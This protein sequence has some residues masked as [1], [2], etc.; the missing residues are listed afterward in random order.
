MRLHL[1]A[2]LSAA[3]AV[4]VFGLSGCSHSQSTGKSSVV[5]SGP[6]ATSTT[7]APVAAPQAAPLPAPEALTDVLYRLADPAVPGSQKL[8]LV[9]DSAPDNAAT[10][11]KFTAALRDNGYLPLSFVATNIAWSDRDPAT[12]VAVVNVKTPNPTAGAFSFPMEFKPYPGGWQLSRKT[13]DTLLAF[14]TSQIRTSQVGTSQVGTS[15]VG[16]ST[17]APPR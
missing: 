5:P 7:L 14:G 11:D 9:E 6:A 3:T 13:A 15:Q 1:I 8:T 17:P 2:V 4:A 16:T 12:V 10:L